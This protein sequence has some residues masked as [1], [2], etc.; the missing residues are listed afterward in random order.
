MVSDLAPTLFEAKYCILNLYCILAGS[1]SVV[2]QEA[3]EKTGMN[4]LGLIHH[5]LAAQLKSKLSNQFVYQLKMLL[6]VYQC[7]TCPRENR[8][9]SGYANPASLNLPIMLAASGKGSE[10]F[11]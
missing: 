5:A 1:I 2:C 6:H 8:F 9:Y 4:A 7:Q 11:L 3:Q 10:G